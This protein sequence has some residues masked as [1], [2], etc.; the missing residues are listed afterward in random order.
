MVKWCQA[1]NRES[2]LPDELRFTI[3][4]LTPHFTIH[5][6]TPILVSSA[7]RT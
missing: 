5:G 3:H 2:S 7:L 1:V 4:G 6:L